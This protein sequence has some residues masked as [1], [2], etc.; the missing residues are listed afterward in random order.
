MIF[1]FT[2]YLPQV[3]RNDEQ[4]RKRG[5][6]DKIKQGTAKPTLK[7]LKTRKGG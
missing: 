5:S 4:G 2:L 6:G 3:F 1:K 7:L